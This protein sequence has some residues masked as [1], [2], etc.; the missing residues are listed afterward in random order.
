[1]LDFA[2]MIA[3]N[4]FDQ[5]GSSLDALRD[6][7]KQYRRNRQRVRRTR[8][9]E[10]LPVFG[11]IASSQFNDPGHE[12]AVYRATIIEKVERTPAC[13]DPR[14]HR[15][16]M[17]GPAVTSENRTAGD[18]RRRGRLPRRDRGGRAGSRRT[19]EAQ[20]ETLAS[21]SSGSGTI[22]QLRGGLGPRRLLTSKRTTASSTWS[23]R[24]ALASLT[25]SDRIEKRARRRTPSSTHSCETLLGEASSTRSF[26]YR[27]GQATS[28]K[29][30]DRRRSSIDLFKRHRLSG[31]RVPEGR[32]A[33][34]SQPDGDRLRWL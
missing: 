27:G 13:R 4:K 17:L 31:T 25:T 32:T 6:V 23:P 21:G 16:P 29:V 2:D 33:T 7:R 18:P 14:H 26:R 15:T 12:R 28:F 1:M 24:A 11:T 10:Q 22:E 19:N 8:P 30:R 3:I 34:L 5:G 20:V 9:D